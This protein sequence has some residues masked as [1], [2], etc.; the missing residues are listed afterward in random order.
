MGENPA[1]APAP[2][3]MMARDAAAALSVCQKTL[4]ALTRDGKL[5]VV[6]IGRAVRYDVADLRRFIEAAKVEG[7]RR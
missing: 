4:W 6:R 5:P 7:S 3:L 1:R 2:V